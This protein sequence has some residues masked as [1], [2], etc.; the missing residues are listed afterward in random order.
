M[1]SSMFNT[2]YALGDN[3]IVSDFC[4]VTTVTIVGDETEVV[5]HESDYAVNIPRS[6]LKI[7]NMLKVPI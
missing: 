5:K 2:S 3:L 6:G 4:S 1:N 7:C